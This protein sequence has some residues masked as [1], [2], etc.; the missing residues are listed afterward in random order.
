M[1]SR[2]SPP[3]ASSSERLHPWP[4]IVA[5]RFPRLHPRRLSFRRSAHQP[6]SV[7]LRHRCPADDPA[8]SDQSTT[9]EL[10]AAVVNT[11]HS[12]RPSERRLSPPGHGHRRSGKDRRRYL[13]S[14][15]EAQSRLSVRRERRRNSSSSRTFDVCRLH[16]RRHRWKALHA[17]LRRFAL[18][19]FILQA[20]QSLAH[21]EF[22]TTLIYYLS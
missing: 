17:S 7:R 4:V 19:L 22:S 21:C 8:I 6:D 5:D 16:H 12:R 20:D 18:L 15:N 13:L 3:V 9:A 2:F 10:A 11:E 14:G 1:S